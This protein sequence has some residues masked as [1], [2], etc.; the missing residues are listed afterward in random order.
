MKKLSFFAALPFLL[1]VLLVSC[2]KE[3]KEEEVVVPPQE[4][5]REAAV[6]IL[7]EFAS[8]L[9]GGDYSAAAE[10]MSTPPGM[11]HEEKTEGVKGILEKNEISSA[12]VVVLAEK[13]TWGK[14]TEVFGD[15]GVAWAERW[16]LDPEDCWG[17]GFHAAETTFVWNGEALQIFR[18][19]DVGKIV[20]A[21]E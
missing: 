17:L 5:T 18:C 20:E 15:R 16:K 9:E 3:V 12:G 14:L 1:S 7:T 10:L 6:A 13:G 11:T 4:P 21:A 8:R 19:D 2:Q